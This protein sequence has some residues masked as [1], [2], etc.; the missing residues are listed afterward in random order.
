MSY[1]QYVSYDDVV[2]AIFALRTLIPQKFG[3][4]FGRH[5]L[6]WA[7]TSIVTLKH[8]INNEKFMWTCIGSV[9]CIYQISRLIFTAYKQN[10]TSKFMLP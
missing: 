7:L 3:N 2:G 5:V 6:R 8:S 9:Y 10:E 4:I 1:K